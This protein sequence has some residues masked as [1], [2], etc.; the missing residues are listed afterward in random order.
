M[1]RTTP[2][3]AGIQAVVTPSQGHSLVTDPSQGHSLVTNL[4][5][6]H[7]FVTNISQGQNGMVN[8]TKGHT[9]VA[10]TSQVTIGPAQSK[11][12]PSMQQYNEKTEQHITLSVNTSVNCAKFPTLNGGPGLLTQLSQFVPGKS[13]CSYPAQSTNPHLSEIASNQPIAIQADNTAA[14]KA[15]ATAVEAKSAD[16]S[17]VVTAPTPQVATIYSDEPEPPVAPRGPQ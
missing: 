13:M 8:S 12:T 10:T 2:G 7:S 14:F 9:D 16:Q 3:A 4:S 5:K 17:V 6:C 1:I 15:D 11:T